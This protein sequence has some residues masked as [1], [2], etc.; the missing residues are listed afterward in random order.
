MVILHKG[1][2]TQVDWMTAASKIGA[3]KKVDNL[4][5]NVGWPEIIEND[6]EF[7]EFFADLDIKPEMS[8]IEMV[9]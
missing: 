7:T 3:Y 9:E 4:I 8:F 5:Q 1:M 2:L 6:Q